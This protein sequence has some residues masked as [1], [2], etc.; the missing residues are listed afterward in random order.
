MVR[1]SLKEEVVSEQ[2][3]NGIGKW[4][5]QPRTQQGYRCQNRFIYDVPR[6]IMDI[7]VKLN[8][9]EGKWWEIEESDHSVLSM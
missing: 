1:K 8:I 4:Y 9:C 2:D 5:S 6:N 7:Q 3:L